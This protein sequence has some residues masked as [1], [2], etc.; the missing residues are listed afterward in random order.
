MR[1]LLLAAV[2]AVAFA[3]LSNEKVER[4]LNLESQLVVE[5]LAL[6]V[7][8][9]GPA[10]ASTYTLSFDAALTPSAITAK[11]RNCSANFKLLFRVLISCSCLLQKGS[12][13]LEVSGNNVQVTIA[14]GATVDFEVTV[15]YAHAQAPFPE[16]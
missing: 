16:R 1:V 15:V 12:D 10:P 11:V 6:S 3:A 5:T 4:T 2:I 8:N 7:K 13:S 9:S 14:A